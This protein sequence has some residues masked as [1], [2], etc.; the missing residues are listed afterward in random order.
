MTCCAYLGCNLVYI[1]C[2]L[3]A[4]HNRSFNINHLFLILISFCNNHFTTFSSFAFSNPIAPTDPVIF[5]IFSYATNNHSNNSSGRSPRLQ[6]Y[7]STRMSLSGVINPGIATEKSF[8]RPSSHARS[9]AIA[10]LQSRN[11]PFPHTCP[12]ESCKQYSP[13]NILHSRKSFLSN[14][15]ASPLDG[16]PCISF[17]NDIG[18]LRSIS[19]NSSIVHRSGHRLSSSPVSLF[20][21]RALKN[22]FTYCVYLFGFTKSAI[23]ESSCN[24]VPIISTSRHFVSPAGINALLNNSFSD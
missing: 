19:F 18:S 13:F 5:S 15:P 7:V 12:S 6:R 21:Y 9:Q 3:S 10:H 23:S 2:N 20:K 22:F 17:A 24:I 11:E 14:V 16:S 1:L 8:V 4:S